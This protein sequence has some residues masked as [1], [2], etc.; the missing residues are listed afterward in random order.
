MFKMAFAIPKNL[1][2]RNFLVAKDVSL[3]EFSNGDVRNISVLGRGSF[4]TAWK[5]KYNDE[6]A[7][8]KIMDLRDEKEEAKSF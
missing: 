2:S 8:V 7:V 5:V 6:L 3:K 1:K 4:G